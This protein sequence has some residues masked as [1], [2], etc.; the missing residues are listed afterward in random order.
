MNIISNIVVDDWKDL[1]SFIEKKKNNYFIQ[2]QE[3]FNI[4]IMK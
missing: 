2:D 3:K 4:I 1:G